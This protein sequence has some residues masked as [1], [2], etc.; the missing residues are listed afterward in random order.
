MRDALFSPGAAHGHG[1]DR[2]LANGIEL[3]S[4][5]EV[6]YDWTRTL[7]DARAFVRDHPELADPPGFS[8]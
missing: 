6:F 4:A 8:L 3:L 7:A 1:I 5:K 2:L